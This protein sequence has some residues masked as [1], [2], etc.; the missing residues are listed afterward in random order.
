MRPK[1]R[2]I[3][4]PNTGCPLGPVRRRVDASVC[5]PVFALLRKLSF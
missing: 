1:A 3:L 4:R 2:P 5:P